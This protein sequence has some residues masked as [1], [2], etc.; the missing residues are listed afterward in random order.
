MLIQRLSIVFVH[1]IDQ[2]QE[3]SGKIRVDGNDIDPHVFAYSP[4]AI[5]HCSGLDDL[6]HRLLWD[7]Q[8]LRSRNG[9]V[10][11]SLDAGFAAGPVADCCSH[12]ASRRVR[13]PIGPSASYAT[14]TEA[15]L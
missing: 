11:S 15:P 6:A 14:T 10:K 1:G 13:N 5:T 3:Y 4:D 9:S 7:V 2:R 8:R 12:V